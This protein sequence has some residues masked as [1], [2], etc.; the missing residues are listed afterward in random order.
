MSGVGSSEADELVK[1]L[2]ETGDVAVGG[3]VFGFYRDENRCC[4]ETNDAIFT[5]PSPV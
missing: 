3:E 2:S 5:D 4:G 1:K